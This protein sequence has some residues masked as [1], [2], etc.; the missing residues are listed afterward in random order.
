MRQKKDKKYSEAI[1]VSAL[2]PGTYMVV[3]KSAD[4]KI[5]KNKF[6]KK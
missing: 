5:Y 3:S 2:V 1:D 4:G 6:I